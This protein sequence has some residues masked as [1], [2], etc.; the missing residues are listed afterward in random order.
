MKYKLLCYLR[1]TEVANTF[2]T[3]LVLPQS[4]DLGPEKPLGALRQGVSIRPMRAWFV[5][6]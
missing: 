4:D 5:L 1:L 3:A 6:S 2:E